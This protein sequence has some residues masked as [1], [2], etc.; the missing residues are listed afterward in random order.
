MNIDQIDFTADLHL[1]ALKGRQ[2]C[3][4]VNS[5][6][7]HE[8]DAPA[9]D[10]LSALAQ[11]QNL[12]AAERACAEKYSA[13]AAREIRKEIEELIE[14]GGLLTPA[15]DVRSFVY[16]ASPKALCLNVA[17]AC[18][19]R[20]A[21]CFA[22]QGTYSGT[23]GLMSRD[24]ARRAVDFLLDASGPRRNLEVDFFGGEPLL[25]VEVVR[26]TV[27]YARERAAAAG[28][29]IAFTLT[30]NAL[31]LNEGIMDYLVRENIG[32]ILSLD[33][34]P[35]VNDAVRLG[36][37]G[38]G[39]FEAVLPRIR[40]MIAKKPV[41]Y[42]V[43]GTFTRKNLDFSK[44]FAYLAELGFENLSLEPVTGGGELALKMEHLPALEAEYEKLGDLI[45]EWEH[46]GRPIHFF[47]FNLDLNRG[48]C[49]SKR[50][51]GCGAGVE[52]LAVTPE[53][54]LYPCHQFIGREGYRMGSVTEGIQSKALVEKFRRNTLIHKDCIRC[55]ARFYC[56]GGCHALAEIENGDISKPFELAC[57]MHQ[58][59]LEVAFYMAAV[60][61][62]GDI[63]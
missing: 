24:T 9:F 22:G 3:L 12:P 1:Y 29:E 30:T 14:S 59:R 2:F 40:G 58:K 38:G 20:C 62:G 54:E 41:S 8:L 21:Y 6:A 35:E 42:Y 4:D 11:S 36:A 51:T 43:R 18:N 15:D 7:L 48:P 16:E 28:K 19:M 55:W 25:N 34:R 61:A 37:D 5:G 27:S 23:R 13:D 17:H 53:G 57:R 26:D 56:G 47:H 50:L 10:F 63:S 60:R 32:M 33:G 39:T 52:Y 49:V 31:L 44:D 45:L 46:A